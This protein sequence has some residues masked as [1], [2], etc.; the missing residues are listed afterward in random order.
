MASI[1]FPRLLRFPFPLPPIE[2]QKEIVAAIETQFARLDD[3]VAALQRSRTRLKRYRASVLK[4]ACEGRLVP[5]EAELARQE[6]R[7]YE[8]ATVLL[9]RIKTEREAA[10]GKKRSNAKTDAPLDTSQLP[11]LPQGWM[12]ARLGG[13]SE[14]IGDVDHKMPKAQPSGVPYISTKDFTP[15]GAIDF[16][17]AKLIGDADFQWLSRKIVPERGDILL[18]RYG[19]VGEVRVV[20]TDQPFQASYSVAIIKMQC[21]AELTGYV[22]TYLR[23][24]EGQSQIASHIRAS[25]QPDVGLA[26]IRNLNIPV[27]PVAEQERIVEEVERRLSVIDQM[28]ATVEVTLKRAESLRQSI[29]RMAFSGRLTSTGSEVAT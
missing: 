24:P 13:I 8:P 29:L 5:T 18:S 9:E 3:A 17:G 21:A 28:E 2:E 4:A 11:K 22:A 23:S 27:P 15:N 12:W 10:P 1:D 16:S 14:K 19:T 25:S 7:S 26:S 20:T 6:G